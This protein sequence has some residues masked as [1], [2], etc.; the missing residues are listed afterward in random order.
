MSLEEATL[1]P[2]LQKYSNKWY[3]SG[4]YYWCY[5]INWEADRY[6]GWIWPKANKNWCINS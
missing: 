6:N 1:H 3:F 4:L 2:W 5:S